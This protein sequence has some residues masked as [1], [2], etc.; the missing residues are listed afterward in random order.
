MGFKFKIDNKDSVE[1]VQGE[2]RDIVFRVMDENH[3]PINLTD[4]A[5]YVEFPKA[6]G[7]GVVLRSN[8]QHIFSDEEVST[9]DDTIEIENHGF[10]TDDLI[11]L[12]K[13]EEEGDAI[14]GPLLEATD[15]FVIVE[16]KDHF[17]L[18]AT[19]GG[20]AINL[21]SSGQ[22]DNT[23]NFSPVTF[24]GDNDE[25][26]GKVSVHLS[27]AATRAMKAGEKLPIELAFI[28]EAEGDDITRVVQMSKAL[29]VYAQEL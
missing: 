8:S 3:N 21:A 28:L 20:E 17:K 18:A 2:D 27:D 11:K 1:I 19:P 22:G 7:V 13:G 24:P 10:V 23:V 5:I 15:Y 14:P 4:A 16:D 9:E 25:I 6:D 29:N 12:I 26:L